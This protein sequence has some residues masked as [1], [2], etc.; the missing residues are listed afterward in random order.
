MAGNV[1][2]GT[3]E[4]ATVHVHI[5]PPAPD[6]LKFNAYNKTTDV[7]TLGVA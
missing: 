4:E 3:P 7:L 2:S 5:A 1:H 6:G